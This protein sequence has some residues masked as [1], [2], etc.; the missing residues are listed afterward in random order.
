[1]ALPFYNWSKTAA[2]NAT[3][4][5]TVNWAEGQSPSSVN[6]SARAMMASIAGWRDDIS[7]GLLT[8]GTSTAYTVTTNQVF[9]S[10]A[11]MHAQKITI[12]MH[13]TN[14]A[15]PTLNV[16][17]LGAKAIQSSISTAVATGALLAN[18]PY[19]LVY[20][21]SNNCFL[22]IGLA[23]GSLSSLFAA[24]GALTAPA[25]TLMVFQQTAAPT[26]WTKQTTHDDKALRVVSGTAS[27]GGTSAFS[28]VFGL[29]ATSG[30]ILTTS[31]LPAAV[32]VSGSGTGG[33][34]T[35]AP[36]YFI[37]S[38]SNFGSSDQAH[39]HPIELRVKYVDLIIASKD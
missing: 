20:S 22:V 39:T 21:N 35:S 29:T 13:A 8:G 27:S 34:T 37:N 30:T 2:S 11:H 15:S 32:Q 7:G 19:E 23:N 25:G 10:L 24:A 4:D 36:Q 12:L 1:M 38:N 26:G 31:H 6:D 5:S 28:T 16:D 14:G 9:D 3:A 18:T 17:G 33:P